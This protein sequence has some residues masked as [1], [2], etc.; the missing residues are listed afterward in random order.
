MKQTNE[1]FMTP[2]QKM[3]KS[4]AVP[5]LL[6]EKILQLLLTEHDCLLMPNYPLYR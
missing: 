1:K 3:G 6:S 5:P 2:L 4:E